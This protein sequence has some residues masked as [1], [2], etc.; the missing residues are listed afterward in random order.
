MTKRVFSAEKNDKESCVLWATY[1]CGC[2]VA[3]SFRGNPW[4]V[5]FQA[6]SASYKKNR[7]LSYHRAIDRKNKS[8]DE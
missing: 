3:Y 1:S 4:S 2:K 8:S 5:H 7:K 6:H